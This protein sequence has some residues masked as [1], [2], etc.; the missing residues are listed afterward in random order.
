MVQDTVEGYGKAIRDLLLSNYKHIH[1]RLMPNRFDK[2][3]RTIDDR[4]LTTFSNCH[5]T[6]NDLQFAIA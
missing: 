3:L 6:P 1:A 2:D 4:Y 5:Y